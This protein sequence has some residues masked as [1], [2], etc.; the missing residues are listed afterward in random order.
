VLESLRW[1]GWR[2]AVSPARRAVSPSI[3]T[4]DSQG[5]VPSGIKGSAFCT[6]NSIPF[7]LQSK[8]AN[9]F[10][11]LITLREG[12]A[13]QDAGSASVRTRIVGTS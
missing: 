3:F 8:V 10:A 2:I 1:C 7:T 9:Q 11:D 13:G 4:C 6:V 5:A 12:A